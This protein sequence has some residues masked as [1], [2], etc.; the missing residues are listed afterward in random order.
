ML[1]MDLEEEVVITM[2]ESVGVGMGSEEG[3]GVGV[4]HNAQLIIN[5]RAER[6]ED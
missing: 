2:M 3:D 6:N 5:R 1:G 4:G